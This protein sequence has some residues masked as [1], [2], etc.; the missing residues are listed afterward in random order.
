MSGIKENGG[1]SVIVD[2]VFGPAWNGDT[3]RGASRNAL[4]DFL[5]TIGAG[6]G[7]SAYVRKGGNDAT[8]VVGNFLLPFLTIDAA[9]IAVGTLQN[10][11]ILVDAGEYDLTDADAPF[12][13]KAPGTYYDLFFAPGVTVNYYGTYGM[14]INDGST[15]GSIFGLGLLRNYS[16]TA[17]AIVNG[18][19]GYTINVV[20]I[21][22]V[23][24][25]IRALNIHNF[26]NVGAVRVSDVLNA[27]AGYLIDLAYGNI[28]NFA[29][30]PALKIDGGITRTFNTTL[31]SSGAGATQSTLIITSISSGGGQVEFNN[32]VIYNWGFGLGSN[33]P[34]C[35]EITNS[36]NQPLQFNYCDIRFLS[37]TVASSLIKFFSTAGVKDNIL[38][39]RCDLKSRINSLYLKDGLSMDATNAISIKIIDSYA[40]MNT[41]GA[42]ITNLITTGSMLQIEPEL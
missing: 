25:Q 32:C 37:S 8:G 1:G 31:A 16:S 4:Y 42:A 10:S 11:A 38:F 41:G 13:L 34:Y 7:N 15:Y 33:S 24:K 26:G 12:G 17:T 23:A 40:H 9:R 21:T 6:F 28:W 19:S 18:L 36:G 3:R 30:Y 2:T 22:G 14:Y 27:N 35:V 20:P 39:K 29:G 5:I